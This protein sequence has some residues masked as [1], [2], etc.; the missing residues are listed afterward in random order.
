LTGVANPKLAIAVGRK[1]KAL[2]AEA[3][4]A[5]LFGFDQDRARAGSDPKHLETQR[6]HGL[7]LRQHDHRHAPHDAVTLGLDRE[8][9]TPGRGMFQHLG[10]AQQA[11][12][13][14]HEALRFLAQH[15]KSGH[16]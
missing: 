10:V 15:R 14:E 2:D 3:L 13:F 11:R 16:R 4:D 7:A 9:A 1:L 8:Q 5:G 6:G 12:E